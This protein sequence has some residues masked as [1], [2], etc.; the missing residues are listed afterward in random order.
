MLTAVDRSLLALLALAVAASSICRK[1][2]GGAVQHG[3]SDGSS[4][5]GHCR[6]CCC[7][8]CWFSLLLC[9]LALLA[10]V[11]SAGSIFCK[12]AWCIAG[13]VSCWLAFVANCA[14]SKF[15]F[16]SLPLYALL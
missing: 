7:H 8:A 5:V 14:A 4:R 1:G 9:L 13:G 6:Y 16:E 11:A 15:T 2:G 10:L 12:A 3:V